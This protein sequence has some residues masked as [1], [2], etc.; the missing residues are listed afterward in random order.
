MKTVIAMLAILA[1]A[2]VAAENGTSDNSIATALTSGEFSLGLRPRYEFVDQD[3][4]DEDANATTTRLRLNYR[5]ADWKNWS[6]FVEFD[7]VF[8]ILLTDYNSGAGTSPNKGEYPIIA[9]PKGSDLNQLYFDYSSSPDWKFRLGRQRILLDNQRFVG[10]VGWR[11]NEQTYDAASLTT[12]AIGNTTLFYSYIGQVRRIFGETVPAGRSNVDTHLLNAKIK[13][14]DDW[15]LTP[16]VYMIDDK[17]VAVFSTSTIGARVAGDLPVG[18][19]KIAL[20]GEFATQSDAADAPVSFDADYAHFKATWEGKSGLSAGVGYESLGGSSAPGEAFRTPM[21]TLHAFNGWADKFVVT[22]DA[23]IKDTYIVAK[24]PLGKWKLTA[25]FHDFAAE[26]GSGNYGS[27]IDL[28]AGRKL[29]DRYGLLIKGAF[30]SADTASAYTDTNK[31]W[32][33]LTA[34]Y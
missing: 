7:H 23:G 16:Y 20:L 18:E 15:S 19:G 32:L 26:T 34:S 4:F 30:F 2:S 17:D 9:D 27:E 10:G 13:I 3:G 5:T 31:F 29:G 24:A 22:P 12:T 14:G 1:A 21:A 33:M 8:N 11:Q 28:S 25:V 6:T